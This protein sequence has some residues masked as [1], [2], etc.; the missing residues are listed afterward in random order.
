MAVARFSR[1][2]GA[3]MSV[4]PRAFATEWSSGMLSVTDGACSAY[5]KPSNCSLLPGDR[6]YRHGGTD[7]ALENGRVTE[8]MYVAAGPPFR[9]D[10]H[11]GSSADRR[12]RGLRRHRPV[13]G[14][15]AVTRRD[16]PF[17]LPLSARGAPGIPRVWTAARRLWS[18]CGS[19]GST[20]TCSNTCDLDG[21]ATIQGWLSVPATAMGTHPARIFEAIARSGGGSNRVMVDLRGAK[22]TIDAAANF[23]GRAVHAD[24]SDVRRSSTRTGQPLRGVSTIE[25]L[26]WPRICFAGFHDFVTMEAVMGSEDLTTKVLV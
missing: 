5:T 14:N 7:R 12:G 1:T 8:I 3:P 16:C 18:K 15:R 13:S 24:A 4:A 11:G 22:V 10:L 9:S 19:L 25:D 6:D 2:Y 26:R 20:R 21:D 17:T 23:S